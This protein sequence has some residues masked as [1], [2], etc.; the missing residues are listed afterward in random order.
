MECWVLVEAKM[1]DFLLGEFNQLS[2]GSRGM[3]RKLLNLQMSSDQPQWK[4]KKNEDAHG[5][6]ICLY[7]PSEAGRYIQWQ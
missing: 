1:N 3:T 4:T 7:Y 2:N 5:E 6:S